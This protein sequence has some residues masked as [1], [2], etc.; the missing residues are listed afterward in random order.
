MPGTVASVDARGEGRFILGWN[1]DL[2]IGIPGAS[3]RSGDRRSRHASSTPGLV[4]NRS[5]TALD[6]S[7]PPGMW[8]SR[9]RLAHRRPRAAVPHVPSYGELFEDCRRFAAGTM[10]IAATRPR[11]R[12]KTRAA[13]YPGRSGQDRLRSRPASPSP[14]KETAL[15]GAARCLISRS[16]SPEMGVAG[17]AFSRVVAL[18]G[19]GRLGREGNPSGNSC[20]GVAMKGERGVDRR[21]FLSRGAGVGSAMAIGT[22]AGSVEGASRSGTEEGPGRGDRLRERLPGLPAEPVGLSV[23][24]AGEHL[25]QD[26][27]ACA[28]RP[29]P[30]SRCPTTIRTSTRCSPVILST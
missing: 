28:S 29:R 25:R 12:H 7:S 13:G 18:G 4:R 27:R 22:L 5:C 11:S 10:F 20:G 15:R 16:G 8:A 14:E 24:G 19:R 23:R 6:S 26:P 21:A 2:L 17:G 1:A 9:P 3:G 30:G